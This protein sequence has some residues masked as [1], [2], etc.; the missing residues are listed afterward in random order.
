VAYL[1]G[2]TEEHVSQP[3]GTEYIELSDHVV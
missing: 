2:S 3:W 1:H